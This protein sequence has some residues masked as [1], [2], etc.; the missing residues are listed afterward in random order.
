[1]TPANHLFV[2]ELQ[3]RG[4]PVTMHVR[5]NDGSKKFF[6]M[7][8]EERQRLAQIAEAANCTSAHLLRTDLVIARLK[9][10]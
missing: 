9:E 5:M 1:M 2:R 6:S 8:K 4:G 3:H 10:I 7:T